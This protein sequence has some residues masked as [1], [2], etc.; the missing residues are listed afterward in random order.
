MFDPGWKGRQANGDEDKPGKGASGAERMTG[1]S[2]NDPIG[3]ISRWAWFFTYTREINKSHIDRKIHCGLNLVSALH[4]HGF[5]F[6]VLLWFLS[7]TK[8]LTWGTSG[9]LGLIKVNPFWSWNFWVG[10]T[11]GKGLRMCRLEAATSGF[12]FCDWK[13]ETQL[14]HTISVHIRTRYAAQDV[15]VERTSMAPVRM[16]HDCTVLPW[17]W[18]WHGIDPDFLGKFQSLCSFC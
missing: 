15:D 16:P 8:W 11:L 3:V 17:R 10:T 9:Y 2:G 1:D 14:D 13:C 12:G 6:S 18:W 5:S 7:E 4:R